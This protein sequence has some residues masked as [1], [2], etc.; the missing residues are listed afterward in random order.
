LERS[1]EE[2]WKDLL[3]FMAHFIPTLYDQATYAEKNGDHHSP[4]FNVSRALDNILDLF[5]S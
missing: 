2:S 4:P 5:V 3:T 1:Q